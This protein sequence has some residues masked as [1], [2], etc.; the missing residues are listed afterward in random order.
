MGIEF[1]ANTTPIPTRLA[2]Y[3]APKNAGQGTQLNPRSTLAGENAKIQFYSQ[4]FL[5]VNQKQKLVK[6]TVTTYTK[7]NMYTVSSILTFW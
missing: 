2:S 4:A 3:H 7:T 6:D 5:Y 1:V